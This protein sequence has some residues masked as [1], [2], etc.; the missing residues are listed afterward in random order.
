[1]IS[2]KNDSTLKK[3]SEIT[4]KSESEISEKIISGMIKDKLIYSNDDF[5]GLF[6]S[7]ICK[8]EGMKVSDT[9]HKYLERSS[10]RIDVLFGQ[11]EF[12]QE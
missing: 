3:L 4:N 8:R 10:L 6:I 11:L 12:Y 2:I 9:A 7:D 1:M 5:G